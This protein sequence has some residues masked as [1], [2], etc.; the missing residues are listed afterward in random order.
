MH[1]LK[2]VGRKI[3]K[4]VLTPLALVLGKA[5]IGPSAITVVGLITSIV[6]AVAFALGYLRLGGAL[7]LLAGFFDMLDG[8]VARAN[9]R[10]SDFG[11][12]L[13]S[14][15]DRYTESFYLTGIVFF[16]ATVPQIYPYIPNEYII[17]I[18]VITLFGSFLVSYT[19][20]RAE[21]LF[22]E[23][24]VG[25]MERPE[26]M[27]LLAVGALIGY[28]GLLPALVLLA[29]L[30]NFTALQRIFHSYKLSKSSDGEKNNSNS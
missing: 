30:S 9:D 10:T 1:A 12:F 22:G 20:A 5:G 24:N 26:R 29:V 3:G 11:A 13:D 14:T 23:C 25:F 19:K 7:I 4:S 28:W 8:T 6:C 18:V 15:I 21:A 2:N 27:I 16:F 17:V